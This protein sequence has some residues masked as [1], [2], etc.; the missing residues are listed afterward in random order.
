MASADGAAMFSAA[1]RSGAFAS[2]S[3]AL[4]LAKAGAASDWGVGALEV[5]FGEGDAVAWGVESGLV[6]GAVEPGDGWA[7]EDEE[8]L[9]GLVGVGFRSL[10]GLASGALWKGCWVGGLLREAG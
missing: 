10:A 7:A 8:A 1:G 5:D 6:E 2:G 3:G 9:A 4:G